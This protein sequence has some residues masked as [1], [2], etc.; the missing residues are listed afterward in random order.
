MRSD[1][2]LRRPTPPRI[3]QSQGGRPAKHGGEFIFGDAATWGAKDALTVPDTR[4][5][6]QVRAQAWTDCT[7][8]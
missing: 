4:F 2:V 7:R 5:Y 6:G 3:Y 8:A 1:R